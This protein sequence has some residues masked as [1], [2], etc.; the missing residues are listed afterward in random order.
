MLSSLHVQSLIVRCMGHPSTWKDHIALAASCG[1]TAV[2]LTPVQKLGASGSA[3]SI[4]DCLDYCH[5]LV[6]AAIS[7]IQASEKR[8]KWIGDIVWN[9]T[10][11]DDPW[12]HLHRTCAYAVEDYPELYSAHQLDV[13][14]AKFST[15]AKM[16]RRMHSQ[17][18]VDE[19][20]ALFRKEAVPWI[21]WKESDA[22]LETA[23]KNIAGGIFYRKVQLGQEVS[24]ECP[25]VEPYFTNG[26]A[27]NGWIF[28]ATYDRFDA[29]VY[30][31]RELIVWSDCIKLNYENGHLSLPLWKRME[32]YTRAQATLFHGIRIDNAHSTPSSVA[33]RMCAV[34]RDVRPD[35]IIIAEHF[36]SQEAKAQFTK[37]CTVDALILEATHTSV[38][39]AVTNSANVVVFDCTHDTA[40]P[41]IRERAVW[42]AVAA[43]SQ[44]GVGSVRGYDEL[45]EVNPPVVDPM[46]DA[47]KK[48]PHDPSRVFL[49]VS[50]DGAE[51]TTPAPEPSLYDP[52][53]IAVPLQAIKARLAGIRKQEHWTGDEPA[54]VRYI[55]KDVF[56]IERGEIVLVANLRNHDF[57]HPPLFPE[58]ELLL[59][60]DVVHLGIS[61]SFSSSFDIGNSSW[62]LQDLESLWVSP[63]KQRT[64]GDNLFQTAPSWQVSLR[65]DAF[66]P[67]SIR[68]YRH[69]PVPIVLH[70]LENVHDFNY[71]LFRCYSESL[72]GDASYLI[73]GQPLPFNG[74]WGFRHAP[75]SHLHSGVWALE[76]TARRLAPRFP[77]LAHFFEYWSIRLNAPL[78]RNLAQRGKITKSLF[79]RVVA[80]LVH[81]LTAHIFKWNIETTTKRAPAIDDIPALD[82]SFR[83]A[84]DGLTNNDVRTIVQSMNLSEM[85]LLFRFAF[86]SYLSTQRPDLLASHSFISNSS[87]QASSAVDGWF[88]AIDAHYD[89]EHD[90]SVLSGKRGSL[91]GQ[92]KSLIDERFRDPLRRFDSLL[93]LG[94]LV[95]MC[96]SSI[97]EGYAAGLPHFSQGYMRQWGRD[98]MLSIPGACLVTNQFDLARKYILQYAG[99]LHEGLVPNL[100][101]PSRYNARDATWF[102]I[103][104]IYKFCLH[105]GSWELFW[106]MEDVVHSIIEKHVKGIHFIDTGSD[107][108]MQPVGFQIDI[109]CDVDGT[110]LTRGDPDA[111]KN[112]DGSEK[113]R[114]PTY[115][116][117]GGNAYN[118]GTWMDKMG[119]SRQAGNSG[120]PATPRDGCPIELAACQYVAISMM[121]RFGKRHFRVEGIPFSY[122][123]WAEFMRSHFDSWFFVDE[124]CA[125]GAVHK[126]GIYRDV[127]GCVS[128]P[129][130][131]Y[132]LRPNACLAMSVA[133]ELFVQE[134]AR[135]HLEWTRTKLVY[136]NFAIS[137]LDVDDWNY[138]PLY[139]NAVDSNDYSTALGFNY[140]NGPPW[141]WLYGHYIMSRLW[142]FGEER[143]L[144]HVHALFSAPF[145]HILNS[146]WCGLP[147][148]CE[149]DDGCITQAWSNACVLEALDFARRLVPST[150]GL[151][152][153][154]FVSSSQ[155]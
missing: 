20:I 112:S 130:A 64:N 12:I 148:L 22:E 3:Y 50:R 35:A 100:Y 155:E 138:R 110:L 36:G 34:I 113:L 32:D 54:S 60:V 76:Y 136:R 96:G 51:N 43:M 85:E 99:K 19:V 144:D 1:Y 53:P 28:G 45:V 74:L 49:S 61:D 37:D 63:T 21:D 121:A 23:L 146:N 92:L 109:A 18:D 82:S 128:S 152:D 123:E 58:E 98:T 10:S 70:E 59:S 72:G 65:G 88:R 57:R 108:R 66:G 80:D 115:L 105:R 25:L 134:H 91:V 103:I 90:T 120:K 8:V 67:G 11:F 150:D 131:E 139:R 27:H 89:P 149:T 102:L 6:P 133:P 33:I 106:E 111:R 126:R 124:Q 79:R 116:F 16:P 5:P 73:D 13:A 42:A 119:S 68:I 44:G 41:P 141:V 86:S 122:V 56:V 125:S 39:Y 151:Q 87:R 7:E 75:E 62:M 2:H 94:A 143:T 132:Q 140:H 107:D 153:P 145:Q 114:D 55:D 17:K 24:R 97:E 101:D 9:H 69:R 4:Q 31:R 77:K 137:T 78:S 46:V 93:G 142:F 81:R 104:A 135:T 47:S 14:L 29:K 52:T 48:R 117:Y 38:E 71:V 83:E 26:L 40:V 15:H 118:A 154:L 30:T 95:E 127:V 129:W 84:S 147:E